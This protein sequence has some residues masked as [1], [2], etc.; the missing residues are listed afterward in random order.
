MH[1]KNE[2]GRRSLFSVF[3]L[4]LFVA[5]AFVCF[6]SS[7]RAQL[8]IP[9]FTPKVS[10]YISTT[11]RL[12]SNARVVVFATS[13][14]PVYITDL[15]W[16]AP[17]EAT[18]KVICGNVDLR[19]L[20]IGGSNAVST[21]FATP[22]RCDDALVV[23]S[24]SGNYGLPAFGTITGFTLSDADF[25]KG[26]SITTSTSTSSGGGGGST[27]VDFET[28]NYGIATIIY[29]LSL[30]VTIKIWSKQ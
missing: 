30:W 10:N 16:S 5:L 12:Q 2:K 23:W 8:A 28:L 20:T 1:S 6:P 29:L 24:D 3:H 18:F 19:W 26:A 7:V 17:F 9:S 27:T 21:S 22:F 15:H 14:D 11:T 4:G 25:N 13:S